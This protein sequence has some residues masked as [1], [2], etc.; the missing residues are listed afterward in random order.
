MAVLGAGNSG[1][2]IFLQSVGGETG[3]LGSQRWFR[4]YSRQLFL[5]PITGGL[6]VNRSESRN[7]A[8]GHTLR[9][10]SILSGAYEQSLRLVR[11][12]R[13]CEAGIYYEPKAGAPIHSDGDGAMQEV[14]YEVIS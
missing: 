9:I 6:L 1:A 11:S 3:F 2:N 4:S 8:P 10:E 7:S 13:E 5:Y 12:I 14:V